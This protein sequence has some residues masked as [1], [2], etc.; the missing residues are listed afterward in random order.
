LNNKREYRFL[1]ARELRVKQ[2][3]KGK[4]LTGTAVVYNSQSC[5]LGGFVEQI[6]P[7]AFTR[8]LATSPDVMCLHEHDPRQGLLGRTISGTLRLSSNDIGLQ[9]EC[10]L[11]NT[12]LGNDVAESVSRGDLAGC[13]FGFCCLLDAWSDSTDGTPMRTVVDADL[14]DVTMTSM[15]AYEAT[16]VSLRSKM[17]PDGAPAIRAKAN[18]KGCECGCAACVA[19]NCEDCSNPNC[20]DADCVCQDERCYKLLAAVLERRAR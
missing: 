2:T 20:D 5:D 13:S 11:P 4:L 10:D 7:C 19:D 15:P 12:T 8:C 6:A 9:F 1:A 16:S 18:T 17:F 14:F 3:D